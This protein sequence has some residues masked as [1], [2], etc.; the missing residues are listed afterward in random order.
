MKD[1]HAMTQSR[2]HLGELAVM[3]S[4]TEAAER[5]ILAHAEQMHGDVLAKIDDMR[6]RAA[7]SEAEGRDYQALVA[8]RGRLE[9]VIARSRQVLGSAAA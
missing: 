6:P 7:Q 4:Q 3:A 8:E 9:H 1:L 5:Q 2:S